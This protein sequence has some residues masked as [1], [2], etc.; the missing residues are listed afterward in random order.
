[1]ICPARPLYTMCGLIRQ[2]E[3]LLSIA[4]VFILRVLAS[5]PNQYSIS[6]FIDA[7]ESLPCTAFF[8]PSVPKYARIDYG[9]SSLAL[10]EFVGPMTALHSLTALS[11]TNSIPTTTSLV[12]N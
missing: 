8:C 6:L 1:M 3:Q 12:M 9:A 10:C 7:C 2:R 5:P 11:F 4:V